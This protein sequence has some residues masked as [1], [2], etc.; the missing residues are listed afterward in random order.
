MVGED[1]NGVIVGRHRS[2]GIARPKVWERA[3]YFNEHQRLTAAI[4]AA[5]MDEHVHS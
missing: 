4:D 5:E 1:A 3:R 2:T